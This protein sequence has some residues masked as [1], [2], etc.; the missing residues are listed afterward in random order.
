MIPDPDTHAITLLALLVEQRTGLHYA[1]RDRAI[2]AGKVRDHA[3]LRG[4][5]SL[6]DFYRAVEYD[7]PDGRAFGELVDSLIVGETY[8]FRERAGLQR[9]VEAVKRRPG[10]TRVWSAACASGEEILSLAAMLADA[11][12]LDR[13]ELVATDLSERQ[14]ARARAG[15]FSA[16]SLRAAPQGLP[17]WIGVA[18][19]WPVIQPEIAARVQWRR[20]N[21]VDS[22]EV[23]A[24]GR[25]DVILCRNVMIYF[26]DRTIARVADGLADAL[27]PGGF[28]LIGMSESLLRFPTKFECVE[29]GG[30]FLYR[31][32]E[33]A[34]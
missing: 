8:F 17:P 32:P 21:L 30:V 7:D 13:A 22:G 5:D 12:V 2:F 9:V 16:R 24:L 20:V 3:E 11:G 19:G 6:L 29:E 27:N 34:P 14:I 33:T 4:F 31:R 26:D 28:L 23:A 25:F 10:R 15:S 1:H 18:D